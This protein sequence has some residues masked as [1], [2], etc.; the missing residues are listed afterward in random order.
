MD[1]FFN[2]VL[3]CHYAYLD[4]SRFTLSHQ[5]LQTNLTDEINEAVAKE[6]IWA[7]YLVVENVPLYIGANLFLGLLL[8]AISLSKIIN[9]N[10]TK[11]ISDRTTSTQTDDDVLMTSG[12]EDSPSHSVYVKLHD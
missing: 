11:N 8:A 5:S 7:K 12:V 3:I 1:I 2:Q 6:D 9:T 10:L 4:T